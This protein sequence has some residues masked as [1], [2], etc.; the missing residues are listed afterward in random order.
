MDSMIRAIDTGL[1]CVDSFFPGPFGRGSVRMTLVETGAGLLVYS[2]VALNPDLL[3]EIAALGPVTTILAPNTYHHL[4][5]REAIAAW[6]DARV[7]VPAGLPEKIGAVDRAEIILDA[8]QVDPT[9]AVEAFIVEG[10]AIRETVLFHRRTGTL[11]TADLVY[12]YQAEHE[13]GEKF[14]FRMIGCYGA[15]K[16]AFYHRFV[17]RDKSS[18]AALI[19]TVRGWPVRRIVMGHGRIIEG[20]EVGPLFAR[21]WSRYA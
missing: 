4:F 12:N 2:P 17:I 18:I 13:R 20:E 16:I 21:L 6:P 5:L 11:I 1:W 10:H 7:L 8:A 3:A 14:F 15:P 9:N 19:E